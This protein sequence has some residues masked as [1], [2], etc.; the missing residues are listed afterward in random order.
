MLIDLLTHIC[1]ILFS[2]SCNF[3]YGLCPGWSQ[4]TADVFNWTRGTDNTP[5]TGTGP[6]SERTSELG[7][8]I[9]FSLRISLYTFH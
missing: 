9:V 7:L 8:H 5:S 4:S 1:L 3:D 2:V 6:S